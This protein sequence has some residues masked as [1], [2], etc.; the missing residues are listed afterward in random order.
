MDRLTR[1]LVNIVNLVTSDLRQCM[2]ATKSSEPR[3]QSDPN[4]EFDFLRRLS[5]ELRHLT[6]L[7][8]ISH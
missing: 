5:Q 4:A 8:G 7:T 3:L 1:L 6:D 2:P